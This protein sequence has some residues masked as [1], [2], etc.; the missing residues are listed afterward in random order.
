MNDRKHGRSASSTGAMKR[1]QLSPRMASRK[2]THSQ[3]PS[4]AVLAILLLR[5]SH[6]YAAQM[7]DHGHSAPWFLQ[8]FCQPLDDIRGYFGEKM[9]FYFAW[10]GFYA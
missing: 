9:A 10:L 1:K 5:R 2:Q 6:T 3:P 8:I 7:M 4:T